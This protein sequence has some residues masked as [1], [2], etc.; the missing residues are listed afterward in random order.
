MTFRAEL[1][2]I[3]NEANSVDRTADRIEDLIRRWTAKEPE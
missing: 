1:I 3:L 2:A